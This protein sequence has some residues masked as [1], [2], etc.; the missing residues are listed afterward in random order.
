MLIG[1]ISKRKKNILGGEDRICRDSE[2]GKNLFKEPTV[3]HV[4]RIKYM[5]ER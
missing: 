5:K 4:A 1:H 3:S 2:V